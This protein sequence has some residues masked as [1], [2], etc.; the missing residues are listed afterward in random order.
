M[1]KGG[2]IRKGRRKNQTRHHQELEKAGEM[3]KWMCK[4]Y[5]GKEEELKKGNGRIRNGKR[6]NQ[7][8]GDEYLKNGRR[9][10]KAWRNKVFCGDCGS[11]MW[12]K[13]G[14]KKLKNG[15][16]YSYYYCNNEERKRK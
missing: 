12:V 1:R 8:R 7:I 11:V 4:N 10:K 5:G 14:G 9:I 3:R 16:V 13:R 6:K 2:R 15:K